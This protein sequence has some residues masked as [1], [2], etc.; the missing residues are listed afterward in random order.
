MENN[1]KIGTKNIGLDAADW[2]DLVHYRHRW[3]ALVNTV[4]VFRVS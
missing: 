4:M 1:I 2:V 3:W